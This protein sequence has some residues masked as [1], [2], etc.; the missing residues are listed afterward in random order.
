M[1]EQIDPS[2]VGRTLVVMLCMHRSGS[3]LVTNLLQRLG[4]SLGTFELLGT[5]EHNK[6]GHFEAVPMYRL[7]QELLT[8]VFG[9]SD[10][11]P[12][13]ADVLRR[14]CACEGQ[15]RLETSPGWQQRI[16]QGKKLVEQ[17]VSSGPVSGFKASSCVAR[18]RRGYYDALDVTAVHYRWLNRIHDGWDGERAVAR[19]D[20][21][22]FTE[23][24]RRA[25]KVCRLDWSEEVFSQVF[26]ATCKHH[27]PAAVEHPAKG[28]SRRPLRNGWHLKQQHLRS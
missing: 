15:W 1:A 7:D 2:Y 20:P 18:D 17:L 12:D 16:E 26:D 13:S 24:L 19:F 23:D 25:A 4:M 27:P 14:F 9:F 3:S 8:Q 21:R 10:D 5:S 11:V 28:L 6:Y 22:M